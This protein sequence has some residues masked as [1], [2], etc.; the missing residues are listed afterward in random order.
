MNTVVGVQLIQL[1]SEL[2]YV[3]AV[4]SWQAII[5]LIP[6]CLL[7]WIIRHRSHALKYQVWLIGIVGVAAAPFLRVVPELTP[8]HPVALTTAVTLI[9]V[10]TTFL[11]NPD[12]VR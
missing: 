9:Q 3:L 4:W 2:G 6:T 5:V 10:P 1:L 8:A 12:D 11:L 7:A